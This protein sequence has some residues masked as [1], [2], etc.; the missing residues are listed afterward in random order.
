MEPKLESLLLSFDERYPCW[1]PAM[2]ALAEQGRAE[3]GELASQ[4]LLEFEKGVYSA[5]QTCVNEPN[6]PP[7]WQIKAARIIHDQQAKTVT[8]EDARLEMLGNRIAALSDAV[9]RRYFALLPATQTLGLEGAEAAL[10][11]A[12]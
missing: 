8:Y 4:G 9:T 2:L 11:G 1:T 5:C 3:A 6:K 7:F 12:A 10:R